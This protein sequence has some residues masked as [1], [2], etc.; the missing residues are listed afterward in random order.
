MPAAAGRVRPRIRGVAQVLLE[1][2]PASARQVTRIVGS[3]R[4]TRVEEDDVSSRRQQFAQ[5]VR[6]D[7]GP[8]AFLHHVIV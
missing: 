7:D 5:G 1:A 2:R 3:V 8:E 6:G 4:R